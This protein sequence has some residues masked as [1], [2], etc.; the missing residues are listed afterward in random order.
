MN[1]TIKTILLFGAFTLLLLTIG[2]YVGGVRGM[3]LMTAIGVFFNLIMYFFSDKIAI[4]SAKAKPLDETQYPEIKAIVKDLTQKAKLPMP[5]LFMNS[6]TQPNAFAT[7]RNPKNSAIMVTKG[8]AD[9]LEEGE[10]KGVLAHELAHIKNRDILISTL[11]AVFA[12]IITSAA[13]TLR[14]MNF[15]G[16]GDSNRNILADIAIMILAPIAAIIIQLAISRSREYKAD[17]TGAQIAGS[18]TGLANA[19]EKIHS[20]SSRDLRSS[21]QKINP[22]FENLYIANPLGSRGFTSSVMKLFST[23]PP[24]EE[25][26]AK[27]RN[28]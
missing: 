22:A 24:I 18:P 11:A 21:P 28:M 23:H 20:F 5:R 10:I 26:V 13:H 9:N 8:L 4:L 25:R 14:W 6:D 15:F 19:L 1:N 17:T 3:W 12:S 7:G 27:L 2:R 16:Q